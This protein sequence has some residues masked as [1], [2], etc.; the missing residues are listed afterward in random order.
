MGL[1]VS[2]RRGPRFRTTTLKKVADSVRGIILSYKNSI[3]II[4]FSFK[5]FL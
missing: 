4:M 5:M 2:G 3:F 1:V